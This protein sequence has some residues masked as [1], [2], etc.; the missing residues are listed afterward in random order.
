MKLFGKGRQKREVR[1]PSVGAVE[2]R[3]STR[4]DRTMPSA[5]RQRIRNISFIEERRKVACGG[6]SSSNEAHDQQ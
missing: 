3:G 5:V 6:L 2:T 4:V 1:V